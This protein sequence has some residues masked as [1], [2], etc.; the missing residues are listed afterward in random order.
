M[1]KSLITTDSELVAVLT[2]KPDE[3][4]LLRE[5]VVLTEQVAA[6]ST[7]SK[8]T[9]PSGSP[10]CCFHCNQ[11]GH[12]QRDCR[13]HKCFNYGRLGHL[14]KDC[15]HQGNGNGAPVQGNRH[16]YQ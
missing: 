3:K 1:S 13:N 2:N 11:V 12:V 10:P 6:L 15:W 8:G 4:Q 9:R 7:S 16:P 5:Q 14:S